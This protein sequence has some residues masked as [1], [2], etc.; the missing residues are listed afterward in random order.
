MEAVASGVSTLPTPGPPLPVLDALARIVD[1]F[2]D[3]PA[4][5]F[6]RLVD[7]LSGALER[8]LSC[9]RPKHQQ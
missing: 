3:V 7:V 1:R 4:H 8:T 6:D 9:T 2:F 5:V